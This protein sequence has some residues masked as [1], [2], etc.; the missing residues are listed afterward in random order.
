M[1]SSAKR[2]SRRRSSF[3]LPPEIDTWLDLVDYATDE[4]AGRDESVECTLERFEIEVPMTMSPDAET[5]TWRFDGT[6]RISVGE[7][8]VPLREWRRLW[9]ARGD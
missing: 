3:D 2:S 5:A 6:V 4:L 9:N 7:V 8:S 1:K